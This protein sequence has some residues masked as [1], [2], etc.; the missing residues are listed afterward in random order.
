MEW[1]GFLPP[2][3]LLEKTEGIERGLRQYQRLGRF[4]W[5]LGAGAVVLQLTLV[6]IPILRPQLKDIIP[7]LSPI[8][9]ACVVFAITAAVVTL[10][11]IRLRLQDAQQPFRYTC[12]VAP[13]KAGQAT[14]TEERLAWLA[15]DLAQK[16]SERVPRLSFFD[17]D[18]AQKR[19]DKLTESH[20]HISGLYVIREA[21]ESALERGPKPS[22][23]IEIM[24]RVRVG[25]MDAADTL[26]HPVTFP[27]RLASEKNSSGTG[28]SKDSPSEGKPPGEHP[29]EEI[30]PIFGRDRYDRLLERVYFTVVSEL[31]KEIR[32]GKARLGPKLPV[33]TG[34]PHPGRRGDPAPGHPEAQA[35]P[36]NPR[37][38]R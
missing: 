15:E 18:E 37:A 24:P 11:F 21:R 14:K 10:V 7:S 26:A 33:G 36:Y 38:S 25:P 6:V 32:K 22:E 35:D 20:I 2:S 12:S 34:E 31:Y 19:K 13:F 1:S 29:E 23:K 30:S 17:P 9:L 5:L 3:N 28:S 8:V 27:W 16:L 4:G